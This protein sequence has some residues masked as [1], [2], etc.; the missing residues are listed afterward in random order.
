MLYVLIT[1]IT[2]FFILFVYDGWIQK[3]HTLMRNFPLVGR[4]RYLLEELGPP[5]RQYWIA[6]DKEERPFHRDERRWVYASAKGENSNFGFGTTEQL[7]EVGHPIIKHSTF[8]VASHKVQPFLHNDPSSIPCAKVMGAF[9]KRK[10]PFHPLSI[11]NISA[12]SFGSLGKKA[13][14]AMG[15][16]AKNSQSFHN[17]GEGGVSDH[18]K[19]SQADLIWQLG[20]GYYG[21]R[22]DSGHF[23]L[24]VLAAEVAATPQIRAIEIK[25][26]QGAKPGKGG[27]LPGAKVTAEIAQVRKIPVGKDCLSPNAHA[28]FSTP[29]ELIDFIE[30][31]ASRT[32]I[33]VGIKSAVGEIHFWK[34]LA[35]RMK[36]R[37]QGPDFIAIDGGEGGTGAAPLAFSDHVSLPFKIGFSRVYQVFLAEQI[38]DRIVWIGS[39]KLGFPDRAVIAFALGCDIIAVARESML[40]IG[41]IQSQL[42]HT[43]HCPA[44]V[45]TQSTWLQR[46]LNVEA[47]GKRMQKYIQSFRKELLALSHAAGHVHPTQFT[48]TDI[49]ICVGVNEFN[50]LEQIFQYKKE[51]VS[52]HH[53]VADV[54]E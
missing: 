47:K 50:S 33:P 54:Q 10:T 9:H 5:L 6:N 7:Y 2:P 17:T 1:L 45:A 49:D 34:E 11:I 40:A 18:H 44:G 42:C 19:A 41:C 4:M 28:E 15:L 37:G 23:N 14:R 32:G 16:G 25:L 48:G 24:D 51:P 21:A 12:M 31:I 8:P 35:N 53:L 43:G 13:V 36:E 3:K 27:I 46:G 22:D 20:T 38:V 26:S 39:G 30:S 52:V 29:D